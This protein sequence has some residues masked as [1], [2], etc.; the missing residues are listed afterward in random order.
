MTKL[1]K[2]RRRLGLV[3][4]AVPVLGAFALSSTSALAANGAVTV[5]SGALSP[6]DQAKVLAY[7]TPARRKAA[8]GV[9]I[10]AGAQAPSSQPT[11]GPDGPPNS[12]AGSSPTG[13]SSVSSATEP[14]LAGQPWNYPYPYDAFPVPTKSYKTY[15]YKVNGTIF[16]DN[17]G[18]GFKCSG[19]A[20]VNGHNTGEVDTAGHCVAN[21]DSGNK[22]DEFAEFIPAYNGNGKLAGEIEPF[23]TFV[24][25]NYSTATE[26]INN[27]NLN[28][29]FGSISVNKS[30]KKRTLTQAVG[31]DGWAYNFS[32]N[33]QYV[34]FGYPGESPYN[35]STMEEN[36]AASAPCS[37]GSLVCTGSP[38][39]GGSS[40]GGWDI[41]WTST[42][43]GY[44]NGHTDFYFTNAPLTKY[45]PYYNTLWFEVHCFGKT[46]EC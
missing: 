32:A 15:P 38:F 39:T 33:E 43:P 36:I 31:T 45:T 26:W 7:W 42:G 30:Q 34:Q 35:G 19:T 25:N 11:G 41:N 29:D 4:I 12:Q 5:Q 10:I 22:F 23:G 2:T 16:F 46:A 21:T 40:G 3:A 17:N 37:E 14:V 8:K 44:L 27:R 18:S 9:N 20:V 1:T 6:S 28:D 24:A 13:V